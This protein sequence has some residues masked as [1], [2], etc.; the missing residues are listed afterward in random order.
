MSNIIYP[1]IGME[2]TSVE[3]A[4]TFEQLLNAECESIRA[5]GFTLVDPEY[6]FLKSEKKLKDENGNTIVDEN[7][8]PKVVY[9]SF[10]VIFTEE[11]RY[12]KKNFIHK[13][14][15][16]KNRTSYRK[17]DIESLSESELK[18]YLKGTLKDFEPKVYKQIIAYTMESKDESGN[19]IEPKLTE[20]GA[21]SYLIT[22]NKKESS[23]YVDGLYTN[24]KYR[25]NGIAHSM[26]DLMH[27]L[28]SVENVDVITMDIIKKNAFKEGM[29]YR[30][31]CYN[32]MEKFGYIP[33]NYNRRN[34]DFYGTTPAI[35]EKNKIVLEGHNP[36]IPFKEYYKTINDESTN[37][38]TVDLVR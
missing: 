13:Y 4:E 32:M 31:I 6:C 7:G 2:N 23:A 12:S 38:E 24:G 5:Q 14:G 34:D 10:G 33:E 16:K 28:V 26:T 1:L 37:D 8:K 35:M 15:Y 17:K 22:N 20:L 18:Y 21:M 36:I 19:T 25:G 30:S 9:F 29:T 27:L 11:I 3:D